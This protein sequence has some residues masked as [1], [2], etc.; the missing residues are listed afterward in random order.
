[1]RPA[2]ARN[3]RRQRGASSPRDR[4]GRSPWERRPRR[5]DG[6]RP[7]SSAASSSRRDQID[8]C[9]QARRPAISALAA[10]SWAA[11][12]KDTGSRARCRIERAPIRRGQIA[13]ARAPPRPEARRWPGRCAPPGRA[14][15]AGQSASSQGISDGQRGAAD[16]Q[17]RVA[18]EQQRR[19][20]PQHVGRADR[21]HRV[22][23]DGAGIAVAG[24]HARLGRD[25]P[26]RPRGPRPAGVRQWPARPPRRREWRCR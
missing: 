19:Q 15:I 6:G 21:H 24:P 16:R 11:C 25:R 3:L 23:G 8:R 5:P 1:M 22:I 10:A 2:R 4:T 26:A 18:V 7:G 14:A 17:R 12:G 20:V 9:P 13:P